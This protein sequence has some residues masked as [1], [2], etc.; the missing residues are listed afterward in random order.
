MRSARPST[1]PIAII[2]MG[3]RFPRIDG[4]EALWDVLVDNVDAVSPVPGDRFDVGDWYD[5][6]P[7]TPGR[8]VSRHGGFLDDPFDFDA[9]FFGISPVEA[10]SMDPQQRL[11]LHVVWEALESAGIPP[12]RL[13]GSRGGVFV[14]QATSEHADT[15]PLAHSPDVRSIV[16]SRLRA[17]TAG[18]VSFALDLRGPSIV[19]DTA[20]SSSLVAVHAARQSLLTGESDLGIA[21]GVNVILSP[22]DSIA[23][24][25]GG[26]L[27]P[28]GRCRFGDADADGFVRS[29]GVGVVVLKRLDDALR[30]GDPVLSVLLGSA[31]TNDG[32]GS[33]L[34]LHP[35]VDGQVDMLRE[36][37]RVAGVEPAQLD[38]VEAHGTGTA[39]GDGVE[40]RALAQSAK[41]RSADRPLLTGS[42]KTNLGHA[43][44]AAGIAGLIKAVL[45]VQRG[46]V[47]ASLHLKRPHALLNQ[48]DSPI[49]VVTS[50]R[51]LDAAG[52]RALLGVSSFGLSGTNAH[53]VIGEHVP[54]PPA[55]ANSTADAGPHLL[56]LS[57][58]SANALRRLAERY[59]EY[60]GPSGPG[61]AQALHD[62][63]AAAATGRDAHP[64]RLWAVGADHDELADKLRTL[65]AGGTIPDGGLGEAGFSGGK[66]TVF[67]YSG[68]GSQWSGMSRVLDER[69]PAFRAALDAC[70]RAVHAELGWSVREV[71]ASDAADFPQDVAT[72]QPVLWAV[73]VALTAA[74]RER[75]VAPALCIG[76][77][78]GEVAAAH[79][80]GALSLEDAAAVICRRSL[81]MQRAAGQ[82]AMLVVELS[83]ADARQA[84]A[85]L[86]DSVCVAAENAPSATVLAG[87][88]TA[89]AR[90]RTALET[91]GVLCRPVKVNVASHSPQMDTLRDDLLRDLAGLAPVESST[92]MVS[93]VRRA[94]VEGPE[95]DAA[96][97]MDNLRRPVRF[98]DTVRE[99][100]RETESVFVEISPHPILA[101]AVDETLDTEYGA[102]TVASL[103]RAQDEHVELAR[104]AGRI[105][106]SGGT[107]DWERWY[108]G[109]RRW[110]P[111]L[112]TY[113]WDAVCFQREAA[114]GDAATR[115]GAP[116]V[117]EID[118]GSWGATADWGSG[119]GVRGVTSV[120][121]AVYLAAML[122]TARDRGP[123]GM[124]EL[125]NV[126][127][128]EAHVPLESAADTVL[129]VTLDD[130]EAGGARAVSVRASLPGAPFPVF[131]AAGQV[132]EADDCDAVEAMDTID[133]ALS[134]CRDYLGA[135]DFQLLAERKGFEIGEAFRAVE[136]LWR[137]DGEAVARMRLPKAPLRA[138]WEVG[139]QSLLAA[140]P[141]GASSTDGCAYLP[142]AFDSVQFY[143]ELTQEFW[144]VSTFRQEN[145]PDSAL[146]D[147]V[148]VEP[149]GR[150]L[151]RFAGIRMRR[152]PMPTPA[153]SPLS[154]IPGLLSRLIARCTAPLTGLFGETAGPPA[155]GLP[156]NVPRPAAPSCAAGEGVTP[157]RRS[158]V[159][160]GSPESGVRA[161]R[162]RDGAHADVFLDHSAALLGMSVGA[163]DERR[164]LRD[165]GLDSLMA[166]QL[167]Q[168]LHR[169]HGIEITA[170]RLLGP[171]SVESIRKSLAGR[172]AEEPH[173][174]AGAAKG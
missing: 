111:S 25:Q 106:G 93:T 61:R 40:F 168:R 134:R 28:G 172:S 140:W 10:R 92:V 150:V 157:V 8:T 33:G 17:I 23:Y 146:A 120:P 160:A 155:T 47:P 97:W 87:D 94:P 119:V 170:G 41:G 68:Q 107:V 108:G 131:C 62:I 64:H 171:E 43:E 147:V 143:G 48:D 79:A 77:S 103:H 2:G 110:V 96:Y 137:R 101:T 174:A 124:F 70:D 45:I 75:G 35:S 125:R 85:S 142:V 159:R 165:M 11:L 30:D 42:V 60:L 29:E 121:P 1:R 173:P 57:A 149:D 81:L 91:R 69:S 49:R 104:A 27:S 32:K 163:I 39:A 102:A 151:A 59:A 98:A 76:H 105:F 117:R 145:G 161:A 130:H 36:A 133:A 152:L 73:Q 9:S 4:V 18:R 138:G 83:A 53:V 167:R 135:Q 166:T 52:P 71:L 82:G 115:S 154:R 51:P 24:S 15:D 16:G 158:V 118:L 54:E 67:V 7:G 58:R 12:S 100:A 169:D 6:A 95:L 148:L 156:T 21:A 3:C 136:H 84:I 74:W 78:M 31:V 13:A 38:Y 128:G 129:R 123:T 153:G 56:V 127:L 141:S 80:S 20:C 5:P 113:P 46:V 86:A 99:V 63:C 66:R 116:F 88:P 34:L 89:L 72:V 114:L 132:V 162:P 55:H 139:L 14:G 109:V 126:E 50:N 90:I 122:D 26:M 144:S 44:A 19:L 65:A 37:C 22:H 112:P 164:S